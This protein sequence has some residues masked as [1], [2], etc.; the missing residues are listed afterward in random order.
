[1]RDAFVANSPPPEIPLPPAMQKF[2]YATLVVDSARFLSKPQIDHE[3]F[4]DSLNKYGA[5]G[6][7]LVNVFTL[8]RNQGDTH[9]VTAVFKRPLA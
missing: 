5:D 1:M 6:W 4:H 2:E 7:E 3:T 9:E 8:A